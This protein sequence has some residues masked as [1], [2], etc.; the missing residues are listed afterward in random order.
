MI[1]LDTTVLAYA[2]GTEHEYRDP[3]RTLLEA[4]STGSVEA[5]TTA[6]VVQEFAH[7]RARRRDRDDATDHAL[8]ALRLLSPLLAITEQVLRDGLALWRR[9]TSLGSFDSV[10]AAA[11]VA[12]GA[13]SLVSADRA[14]EHV[15]GLRHVLPTPAGVQDLLALEY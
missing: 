8:D 12:H 15:R 7:V 1:V 14:F 3:C 2:V 10:L 9:S 13:G 11:A 4:V 5:T 6:E